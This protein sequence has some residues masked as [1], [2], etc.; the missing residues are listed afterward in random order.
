MGRNVLFFWAIILIIL[1]GCVNSPINRY[2]PQKI[3]NPI[4]NNSLNQIKNPL[5]NVPINQIKKIPEIQA[6]LI[7][8]PSASIIATYLDNNYASKNIASI[9][10]ECGEQMAEIPYYSVTINNTNSFCNFDSS[11]C[12]IDLKFYVDENATKVLCFVRPVVLED[13]N[14]TNNLSWSE[15]YNETDVFFKELDPDQQFTNI[16][17][18]G[19]PK[20]AMHLNNDLVAVLIPAKIIDELKDN[21]DSISFDTP[22]GFIDSDQPLNS[23]NNGDKYYSD[24]WI[25]D[26]ANTHFCL[27][28]ITAG[29]TDTNGNNITDKGAI[30]LT[31]EGPL[32][33]LG[34]KESVPTFTR[35]D[36][37]FDV[38]GDPCVQKTGKILCGECSFS[39]TI[40][41]IKN[42]PENV[43]RLGKCSYCSSGTV[44]E[45]KN[46]AGK[47]AGFSCVTT[48]IIKGGQTPNK[49]NSCG[50]GYCESNGY[51]CPFDKSFFCQGHC[52]SSEKK[53]M[54]ASNGRC[55]DW[56]RTC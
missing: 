36:C 35:T 25:N 55:V 22:S 31:F 17:C 40:D 24:C 49:G 45:S 27:I 44:C 56:K 50:N 21:G 14:I 15:E 41:V 30:K 54:I 16:V 29:L 53:A 3:N 19:I 8:N 28:P 26:G 13:R 6:I 52:Y 43:A 47:C 32:E 7:Q 5:S 34:S 37:E 39:S 20:N 10:T 46:S 2:V 11:D 51:C 12:S 48:E 23:N 18:E 9:S 33:A 42:E 1:A 4:N 38:E